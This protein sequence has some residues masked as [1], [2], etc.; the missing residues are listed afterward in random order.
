VR[1]ARVAP[2][3]PHAQECIALGYRQD[4]MG[5][6]ITLPSPAPFTAPAYA[7]KLAFSGPI[8]EL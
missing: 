5:L 7:M 1:A 2:D 6:H 8:P 4:E 3:R